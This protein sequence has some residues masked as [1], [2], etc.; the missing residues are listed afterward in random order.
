M[1]RN[2]REETLTSALTERARARTSRGA[3]G[4]PR[5]T[6]PL[7]AAAPG[8]VPSEATQAYLAVNG[9]NFDWLP[10]ASVD[11]VLTDPPYNISRHTNLASYAGNT[12]HSFDFDRGTGWDTYEDAEF[13]S[14]LGDWAHGFERVLRPD[15]TFLI[16]TSHQSVG[17]LQQHLTAAGLNVQMLF[18]WRKPNPV[19]F[20]RKYTMMSATEV[21]VVGSK[22]IREAFRLP[23]PERD[24]QGFDEV[25]PVLVADE[26]ANGTHERVQAAVDQVTETGADRPK[27]VADAVIAARHQ[28]APTTAELVTITGIP[29]YAMFDVPRGK[30][31]KSGGGH[32]T[33]KPLSLLRYVTALLTQPNAVILDAFAGSGSV[34]VAAL[35]MGRRPVLVEKDERY[36]STSVERLR[37]ATED[38][39]N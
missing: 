11:C 5:A 31:K 18:T 24:P 13:N 38:L 35:Q 9:D 26:I 15:G 27:A 12:V 25:Y 8:G 6:Q 34:G 4:F 33:Q 1:R 22:G 16:F 30:E 20:N 2:R 3:G 19:P 37:T 36:W 10:P 29:N 21:A 28:Y 14:L 39:D 32:P 17:D 7:V 23:D